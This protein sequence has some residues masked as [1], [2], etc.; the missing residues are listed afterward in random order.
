MYTGL[1]RYL[2]YLLLIAGKVSLPATSWCQQQQTIDSLQTALHSSEGEKRIDL[3]EALFWYHKNTDPG[4]AAEYCQQALMLAESIKHTTALAKAYYINGIA[5]ESIGELV[6]AEAYLNLFL[7]NAL[8]AGDTAL[9]ASALN[10]LG[11][12]NHKQSNYDKALSFFMERVD[13]LNPDN[14]SDLAT[15]YNNIGLIHEAINNNDKAL[16]YFQK[17]IAVHRSL[18]NKKLIGGTLSNMGVIYFKMKEYDTAL[19]YYAESISLMQQLNEKPVLSI[20]YES[21]GNVYKEKEDYVTAGKQYRTAMQLSKE[22]GDDYGIAS[23]ARNMGE[24]ALF[25]GNYK[26][27]IEHLLVSRKIS[28][29]IGARSFVMNA[30]RILASAY[31]KTGN[32]LAA[33]NSQKAYQVLHDSLFNESKNK[34][35]QELQT[36]YETEK[37]DNEIELLNA[38]NK[39][40]AAALQREKMLRNTSFIGLAFIAVIALMTLNNF[41]QKSK[42]ARQL[43]FKNEEIN[44]QKI[45]Q[46]EKSKKIEVMNAVMNTEERERTRIAKDLHDGLSGLLAVTRMQFDIAQKDVGRD[47]KNAKFGY[48]M[49]SLDTA[50]KELRQIAHNMMPEILIKYGLVEALSEFIGNIASPHAVKFNFIHSGLHQPQLA[51]NKELTIYRVIQELLNNIIKHARAT[52]VLVQLAITTDMLTITVE[53]NGVGFNPDR[54]DHTKG[55]G[56]GNITSRVNYLEGQLSIDS[57]P[58]K[59]TS[60]YIEIPIDNIKIHA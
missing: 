14:Q 33:Y 19:E 40:K 3:L 60:V 24:S 31:E 25:N 34:Q 4:K 54:V 35:I 51:P 38:D 59:G 53:D 8:S 29:R 28:D 46:L 10:A 41:R 37:K 43:A 48:A 50:C 56:L 6:K 45:M 23:V 15:N 20:L 17:A 1:L 22:L 5:K 55:I 49:Q 52:D 26:E 58:G 36:R 18:G 9:I 39:V 21:M 11:T 30:D 7:E 27:A 16:E 2:F 44:R 47:G 32:Y 13:Y 12:L 42:A 57:L